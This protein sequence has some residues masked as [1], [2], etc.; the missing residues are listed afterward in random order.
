MSDS[1]NGGGQIYTFSTPKNIRSFVWVD[2]DSSNEIIH[3]TARD[4][5]GDLINEIPTI[6]PP[7]GNGNAKR[8]MFTADN[9]SELKFDYSGSGGIMQT[10]ALQTHRFPKKEVSW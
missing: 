3:V 8:I 4:A 7:V 2:Q 10:S 9:A 5:N 6:S 1:P